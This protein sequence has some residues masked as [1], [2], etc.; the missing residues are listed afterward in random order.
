MKS[1]SELLK[2]ATTLPQLAVLLFFSPFEYE[3]QKRF[4]PSQHQENS[5]DQNEEAV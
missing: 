2:P 4:Y 1:N 5:F 3:L